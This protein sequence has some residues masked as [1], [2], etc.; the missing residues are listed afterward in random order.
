MYL[1]PNGSTA[2]LSY[3]INNTAKDREIVGASERYLA[4]VHKDF[5]CEHEMLP[6][7]LYLG[8]ST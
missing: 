8:R 5:I 6:Q 1:R 2:E 4:T 3:G 7:T